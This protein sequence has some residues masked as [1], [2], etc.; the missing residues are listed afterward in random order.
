MP[1]VSLLVGTGICQ[2]SAIVSKL[3]LTIVRKFGVVVNL[4][5][6]IT[7]LQLMQKPHDFITLFVAKLR[8][9]LD[10]PLNF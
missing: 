5:D 10:T 7:I 3:Q 8:L 1:C 9:H 2:N 6:V 4:T